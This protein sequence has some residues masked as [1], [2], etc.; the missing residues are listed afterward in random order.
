MDTLQELIIPVHR[1]RWETG[2]RIDALEVVDSGVRVTYDRAVDCKY[3][4]SHLQ[5]PHDLP[6]RTNNDSFTAPFD[7]VRLSST[8]YVKYGTI[9]VVLRERSHASHLGVCSHVFIIL[10]KQ[11]HPTGQDS[12]R[13]LC[14]CRMSVMP[15]DL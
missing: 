7:G 3:K 8:R 6:T 14:C 4:G 11:N 13:P 5:S 2:E 1:L 12:H 15:P 9:D 10:T